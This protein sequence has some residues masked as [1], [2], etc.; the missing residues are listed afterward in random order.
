MSLN[1][2]FMRIRACMATARNAAPTRGAKSPSLAGLSAGAPVISSGSR[3]GLVVCFL[4]AASL[5]WAGHARACTLW[6]AAGDRVIGGGTLLAKNR[7]WQPTDHQVLKFIEPESGYQHFALL[8]DER[9]KANVSAGVNELGLVVVS[10]SS[11][12]PRAEARKMPR[13]FHLNSKL[14]VNCA[15]VEEA[16]QREDWFLGPRF[17]MLADH[18][19]I[20]LVEI[21]PEGRVAI[22]RERLGVLFH[23]NH[24]IEESLESFNPSVLGKSTQ[25]RLKK[26]GRFMMSKAGFSLGDFLLISR[27]K[28]GGPGNSIW[29]DGGS[30]RSRRTLASWIIHLLPGGDFRLRVTLANPGE[31][32]THHSFKKEDIFEPH[33]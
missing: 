3:Y 24:Y 18:K 2:L 33:D 12:Y 27:S 26:I 4:L 10:A 1:K 13:T 6:A 19:E 11:P 31:K 23:T 28:E 25:S 16:L 30:R 15:S 9:R 32:M 14:L 20:A 22:K 21:G 5:L 29:R 7:D 8:R 17:L